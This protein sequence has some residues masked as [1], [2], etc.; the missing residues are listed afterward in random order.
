VGDDAAYHRTFAKFAQPESTKPKFSKWD[1]LTSSTVT[2][3]ERREAYPRSVGAFYAYQLIDGR[4]SQVR[5]MPK[6]DQRFWNFATK[7][8][9]IYAPPPLIPKPYWRARPVVDENFTVVG[10]IGWWAAAEVLIPKTQYP[11]NQLQALIDQD[12]PVFAGSNTMPEDYHGNDFA[13]N[14]SGKWSLLTSVDG[15]VENVLAYEGERA[16]EPTLF[17]WEYVGLVIVG[18]EVG[19][20]GVALARTSAQCSVRVILRAGGAARRVLAAGMKKLPKLTKKAEEWA[21]LEYKY[22]GKFPEPGHLHAQIDV[23]A[24]KIVYRIKSIHLRG[25]GS[26]AELEARAAH[27]DMMKRSALEA[28]KRGQSEF[29]VRGMDAG[30]VFQARFKQ[31]AE[32]IGVKNSGKLSAGSKGFQNFEVRLT[33]SKVLKWVEEKSRALAG[34][35]R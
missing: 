5:L 2:I 23:E 16:A 14:T 9:W 19:I 15:S 8:E 1:L 6:P 25:N 34:A 26:A 21:T 18:V 24:G 29:T 27:L 31:L 3:E 20:A 12:V 35:K 17:P 30:P 22:V 7:W 10:Y 28:Q 11:T 4:L 32:R 33:V 13:G